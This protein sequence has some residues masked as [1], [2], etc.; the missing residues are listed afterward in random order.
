M[1][2]KEREYLENECLEL[3]TKSG[4]SIN[5]LLWNDKPLG[6]IIS[7]S[8]EGTA[9][10]SITVGIPTAVSNGTYRNNYAGY[11]K[12]ADTDNMLYDAMNAA[13][14]DLVSQIQN[15]EDAESEDAD[16]RQAILNAGE[17]D[18]GSEGLGAFKGQRIGIYYLC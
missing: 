4:M 9:Y 18:I 12:S 10:S 3:I 5:V 11:G 7:R 15:S 14:K 13:V 17:K 6:K 16:I 1:S 2:D 8:H